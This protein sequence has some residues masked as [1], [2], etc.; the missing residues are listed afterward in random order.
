MYTCIILNFRSATTESDERRD[1]DE[2]DD[3]VV[4]TVCFIA[5]TVAAIT[6]SSVDVA[7][8]LDALPWLLVAGCF[9][10]LYLARLA[11]AAG[12]LAK[13]YVMLLLAMIWSTWFFILLTSKHEQLKLLP[14]V[15]MIFD[16]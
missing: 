12:S 6:L 3:N 14:H 9:L 15:I 7:R 5:N 13:T 1:S 11:F 8:S 2:I 10:H 4:D 16:V